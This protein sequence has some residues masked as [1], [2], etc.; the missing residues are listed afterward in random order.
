MRAG[1]VLWQWVAAPLSLC[2]EQAPLHH[3][4]HDMSE[5]LLTT[6]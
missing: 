2:S 4:A 1:I 5:V 3:Y 6:V